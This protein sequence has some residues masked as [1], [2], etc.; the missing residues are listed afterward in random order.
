M[1]WKDVDMVDMPD[2]SL[3]IPTYK[4]K[5]NETLDVKKAR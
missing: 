1:Q 4:H 2:N 5:E 3:P